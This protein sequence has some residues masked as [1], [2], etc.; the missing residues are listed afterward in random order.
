[1]Y[2][3]LLATDGDEDRIKS[4]VRAV[5]ELPGR[6]EL[7]VTVLYVH[8]EIDAPADEAGSQV[9]ER[10]NERIQDLQS[11]PE[12]ATEA[13]TALADADIP[14]EVRTATGDP[15]A[16]ILGVAGDVDADAVCVAGRK[17]SPIGKAIFGSVTQQVL[18]DSDR[19][20]IVAH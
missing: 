10:I 13:R 20:V 8:E 5:R 15:S 7:T 11:V 3:V 16:M 1:M 14:A 17:R 9:I 2:R 12:S 4:Q 6:E 18:L 19:A